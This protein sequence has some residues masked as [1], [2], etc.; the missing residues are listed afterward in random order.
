VRTGIDRAGKK[1]E[2]MNG[3]VLREEMEKRSNARG[4][5]RLESCLD[6]FDNL[7]LDYAFCPPRS[8]DLC[9]SKKVIYIKTRRENEKKRRKHSYLSGAHEVQDTVSCLWHDELDYPS[10]V[11]LCG[12]KV[13]GRASVHR[14]LEEVVEGVEYVDTS[15]QRGLFSAGR[16]EQVKR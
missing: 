13:D 14:R 1:N 10:Q 16:V 2:S 4:F 15:V 11:S 9:G 7:W 12:P 8:Q 5:S 3:C 6:R